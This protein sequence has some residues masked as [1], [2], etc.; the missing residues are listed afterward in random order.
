[1]LYHSKMKYGE[2]TMAFQATAYSHRNTYAAHLRLEHPTRR[3]WLPPKR[4]T[5]AIDN[6]IIDNP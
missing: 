2:N 1:M 6:L 3:A 4:L 5:G